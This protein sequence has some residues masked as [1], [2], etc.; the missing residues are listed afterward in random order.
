MRLG[1]GATG[2]RVILARAI[3][4]LAPKPRETNMFDPKFRV[5]SVAAMAAA[6]LLAAPALAAAQDQPYG[7]NDCPVAEE[8]EMVTV[9]G[10]RIKRRKDQVRPYP[11]RVTLGEDFAGHGAS[12]TGEA[13]RGAPGMSGEHFDRR[14]RG[15]EESLTDQRR[16]G[17]D[18]Q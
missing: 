8:D 5:N 16:C 12:N 10:S 17:E 6:T 18:P 9:T 7:G 1:G 3:A 14:Y 11:T 15:T 13:F 2:D 4:A